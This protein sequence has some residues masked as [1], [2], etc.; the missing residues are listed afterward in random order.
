MTILEDLTAMLQKHDE[1]AARYARL[2]AY[3]TGD[4]P[5]SYLAPELRAQLDN[6]LDRVS[7][8]LPA[9]LLDALNERMRVLAFNGAD[10]AAA[11]GL[12]RRD[13]LDQTHAIAHR[14]AMC[15]GTSYALVWG[16]PDGRARISVESAEQVTAVTDP[17]TREIVRAVKRWGDA[18]GTTAVMYEADVVRIFRSDAIGASTLGFRLVET[19]PHDLGRVPVVQ[20]RNPGRLLDPFGASEIEPLLPLTDA[21]TKLATD[22]MIGSEHGARPRRWATGV[23]L[24]ERPILDADG[25]PAV[26]EFG[27]ALVEAVVPFSEDDR[28]LL[29]ESEAAKFGQLPGA[30]LAGYEKAIGVIMRMVSAVSG[31]PEHLLGIGG[32]NPTSADSI[33]AAESSLTAKAEA[34]QRAFGKSWED[35]ARLAVAIEQDRRPEGVDVEVRWADPSTRSAAQEADALVKLHAQGLI[36]TEEARDRLGLTT[37]EEAR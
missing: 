3:D 19:I 22:L 30:D 33:R 15:L 12:W 18:T 11:Y 6:R 5:L 37:G 27:D 8:G 32:D 2:N 25:K 4:Q 24:E 7:I 9:V 36:T 34:K 29:A 17:G 26:D 20:L 16:R 23:E 13:D 10:G 14:E 28:M 35:V 21:A 31:L 1:R